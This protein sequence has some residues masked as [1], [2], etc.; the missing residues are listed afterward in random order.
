MYHTGPL[1]CVVKTLGHLDRLL[2][3]WSGGYSN[4]GTTVVAVAAGD[5]KECYRQN[6]ANG[7]DMANDDP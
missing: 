7:V 4:A 6:V 1:Q 3:P 2:S 5:S